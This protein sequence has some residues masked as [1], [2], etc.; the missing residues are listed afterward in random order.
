LGYRLK[1]ILPVRV[2]VTG[3]RAYEYYNPANE[4]KTVESRLTVVP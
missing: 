1:A 3:V 2:A 4:A